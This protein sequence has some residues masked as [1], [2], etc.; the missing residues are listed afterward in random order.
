[1]FVRR[2]AGAAIV[3]TRNTF[4]FTENFHQYERLQTVETPDSGLGCDLTSVV[5]Q[6]I[7]RFGAASHVSMPPEMHPMLGILAASG[8]A[9]SKGINGRRR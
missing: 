6:T 4:V 8:G 3:R 5:G 2:A 1:V 7:K 9:R